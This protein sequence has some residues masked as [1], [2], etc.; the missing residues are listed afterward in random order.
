MA[1]LTLQ[2]VPG[3]LSAGIAGV[4][5]ACTAFTWALGVRTPVLT[6]ARQAR[7]FSP[8]PSPQSSLALTKLYCHK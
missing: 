5:W 2:L 4:L 7:T 8:E 1:S 6:L 3:T